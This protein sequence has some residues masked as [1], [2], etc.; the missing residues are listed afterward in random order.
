[1]DSIGLPPRIHLLWEV[2]NTNS[3]QFSGTAPK[4]RSRRAAGPELPAQVNDE[5]VPVRCRARSYRTFAGFHLQNFT[6]TKFRIS[7][8]VE[9][10][11]K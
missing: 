2:A 4:T 11:F 1:L 3:S 5:F 8:K 10:D 6:G 9:L 7:V